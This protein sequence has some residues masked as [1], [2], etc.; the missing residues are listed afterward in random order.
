M[1]IKEIPDNPGYYISEDGIV[2]T[3][4]ILKPRN[5]GKGY[6]QVKLK[7]GWKYVHRLIVETFSGVIP[8]GKEVHHKDT[9]RSNNVLDNLE[10][11]DKLK[12]L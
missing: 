12:N 5:N 6:M 10:V 7:S 3:V 4:R 9:I 8:D 2:F 1:E 11:V